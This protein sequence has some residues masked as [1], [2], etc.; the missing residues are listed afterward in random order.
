MKI[1]SSPTPFILIR[2]RTQ[3]EWDICDFAIIYTDEQWKST[4]QERLNTI[5]SLK[6][7]Q[8]FYCQVYWDAPVGYF[9]E[10][11][12]LSYREALNEVENG[13][14]YLAMETGEFELF[15]KP[16]SELDTHMLKIT[17][18]GYCHFKAYG[19]HTGEEFWTESFLLAKLINR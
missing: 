7:N 11:P 15:D 9:C 19:K 16:D 14:L 13:F 6:E 5:N 8:S 3:S 18:E 4:A 1:S 12:V 17:K 10:S 2:A